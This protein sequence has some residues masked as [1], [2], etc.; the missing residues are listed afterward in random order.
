MGPLQ[1]HVPLAMIERIDKQEGKWDRSHCLEIYTRDYR[2]W[3]WGG[4]AIRSAL[5]SPL[6]RREYVQD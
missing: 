3:R 6:L 1:T 4:D 2:L 5:R